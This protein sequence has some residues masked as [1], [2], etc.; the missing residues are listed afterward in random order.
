MSDAS[1]Q[2]LGLRTECRDNP[3][4]VEL[5]RP[6]LSWRLESDRIGARQS[7]YR[8]RVATS[9]AR[10]QQGGADVWDS[11]K[12]ASPRCF[13]VAYEGPSLASRRR[14]WWTVQVWDEAGSMAEA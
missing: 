5:Q 4:G 12:V 13:D 11:G 1:L 2:V 7:A 9:A 3:L 6:R 14:C 10:L 8:V